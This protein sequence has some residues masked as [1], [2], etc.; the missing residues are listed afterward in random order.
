MR[1]Y[2][3]KD[4]PSFTKIGFMINDIC[5]YRCS[6]CVVKDSLVTKLVLVQGE[7][8][9]D[10]VIE[11]SKNFDDVRFFVSGGEPL[12][13][14]HTLRYFLNQV[15]TKNVVI[16]TNGLNARNMNAIIK[17]YPEIKFSVSV[18]VDEIQEA[19]ML[20]LL[21]YCTVNYQHIGNISVLLDYNATMP[22]HL[23]QYIKILSKM[24]PVKVIPKAVP[25]FDELI[26]QYGCF[27]Y[28][29]GTKV[30]IDGEELDA[31]ALYSKDNST[32]G[33]K[34][35]TTKEYFFDFYGNTA[36]C[37]YALQDQ[38]NLFTDPKSIIRTEPITC[39]KK[40]CSTAMIYT[41]KYTDKTAA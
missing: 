20:R 24:V 10:A 30:L 31:N 1:T 41:D 12:M 5:Q 9:V 35:D 19:E 4:S 26:E 16:G 27:K 33:M 6:Y 8:L 40:Y 34:C 15:P 22:L 3:L 13:T 37:G 14:V 28:S 29:S 2:E 32:L 17:E 7:K 11:F 18:H 23:E 36:S 39:P 25:N 38:G 21:Q